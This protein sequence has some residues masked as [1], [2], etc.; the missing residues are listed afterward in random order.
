MLISKV[1]N[2]IVIF[3]VKQSRRETI[4]VLLEPEYN[5]IA[6]IRNDG[7]YLLVD[8]AYK[9]RRHEFAF[10]VSL[11]ARVLSFLQFLRY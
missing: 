4:L 1:T 2:V 5:G 10:C 8:T 3:G 7:N 6:N 11:C 9:H